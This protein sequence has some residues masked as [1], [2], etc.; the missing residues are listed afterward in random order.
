[1]S[2]RRTS[3]SGLLFA[4]LALV[5]QLVSGATIPHLTS[6]GMT[7]LAVIAD[8]TT[9][10]H[11]HESSDQAPAPPHNPEDCQVCPLC[12]SLSGGAFAI[13]AD[14]VLPTPRII[15]VA[16]TVILPPATAPPAVLVLAAQPRGPPAILT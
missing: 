8:A 5:A 15:L 9:I 16:P 13:A 3:A 12:A 4:L 11:A 7:E 14:P 6:L 2:H 1:M 10:C